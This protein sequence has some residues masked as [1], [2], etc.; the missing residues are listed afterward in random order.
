VMDTLGETLRKI[1]KLAFICSVAGKPVFCT[2]VDEESI[3]DVMATA[4][5]L[6]SVSKACTGTLKSLKYV[7]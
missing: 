6:V 1:P 4:Q 2:G 5:A 7:P 3:A